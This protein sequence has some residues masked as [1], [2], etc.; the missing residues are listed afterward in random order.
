MQISNYSFKDLPFSKLFKT[1]VSDFE[2]LAS[3]YNANPF[4]NESIAQKIDDFRFSGNRKQTVGIL[5]EFNQKF[6]VHRA[7]IDNLERLERKDAVAIVTGQQLGV[8]GGPLYTIFK[9]LGVIFLA[10]KL[11]RRF[12]IPVIPVFWL[13]DEDHDYEEVRS[14]NILNN[15]DVKGFELPPQKDHQATVAETKLPEE[16][17]SFRKNI[18]EALFNTDFSEDLW[19]IIDNCFRPG[20]TFLDA[21]GCFIACLFSKH[22]LVLAGSNNREVKKVTRSFLQD[23]ISKADSIRQALKKKT[24]EIREEF[25]QQVTLYDSNLFLLDTQNG[26]MKISR[27]GDGWRTD[28]GQKWTT[29]ALLN[30]R[31][32]NPQNFSP[33]VFLRP[34]VQDGLLPTLGYVAGPGETAYYGQMKNMYACFDLEMPIIFPR[35]SATLIEPAIDRIFHELPFKFH[36]YHHRIEDLESEFVDRTE[37]VDIEAIFKDWK[38]KVEAI[39]ESKREV[40]SSIDPTLDGAAGKATAT[41]YNEL[42]KLKGK[43]YR[44]VKKQEETQLN[45]IR[46]IKANFFPGDG[47]QER[48]IS[49]IFYMNKYGVDIWD[50]LLNSLEED[51]QFDHHKL[52]YL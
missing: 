47:L 6:D 51:E 25:H 10:Q 23:S 17:Q 9:T 8:Y 33:N 50:K 38:G 15:D 14:L 12:D 19:K 39:S 52:I 35:L 11:E 44:A 7:A 30:D 43:V 32:E 41:Y 48:L 49:G 16:L 42:N 3:F 40:I 26:R 29:K 37:Q 4:D 21:F 28:S 24:V 2:Q 1:Y 13:A 5:K 31:E 27:N 18:K 45:R 46:R 34:L 20:N 22:G 36:E